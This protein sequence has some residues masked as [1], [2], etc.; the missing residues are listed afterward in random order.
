MR[1]ADLTRGDRPNGTPE[2]VILIMPMAEAKILVEMAEAAAAS[3]PR[4][5]TWAKLSKVLND[6]PCWT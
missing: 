1:Y 6:L 5:T 2:E 4:K 3:S